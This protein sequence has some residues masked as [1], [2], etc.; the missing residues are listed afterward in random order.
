MDEERTGAKVIRNKDIIKLH[1]VLYTMQD[2][3]VTEQKRTWLQD[4]LWSMTARITGMPGGGGGPKGIDDKLASIGEMEEKYGKELDGFLRELDEAEKILNGIQS[5]TMRIFVMMKYMF[6]L[7]D[8]EIQSKL[9]MKRRRYE[10]ARKAIEQ[11]PDMAHV[12]W[13]E[14]YKLKK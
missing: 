14:R 1:R 4:R 9:N 6:D 5:R 8:A 10:Q 7:T 2:V 13:E 3:C 11:A 12:I